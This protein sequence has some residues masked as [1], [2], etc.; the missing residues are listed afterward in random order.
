MPKPPASG[1]H[2]DIDGLHRSAGEGDT[3]RH[4]E[5]GTAA[6]RQD[7][8]ESKAKPIQNEQKPGGDA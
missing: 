6:D 3:N 7:H 4:R 5:G 8:H 2:S 1:P